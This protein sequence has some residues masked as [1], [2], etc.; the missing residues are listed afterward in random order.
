MVIQSNANVHDQ[1]CYTVLNENQNDNYSSYLHLNNKVD[2]T[3]SHPLI[4][5]N[6]V[7]LYHLYQWLF[8][9]VKLYIRAHVIWQK[10]YQCHE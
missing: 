3:L 2:L 5:S 8:Q 6:R 1:Y 7:Y 10:I 4:S 9:Y